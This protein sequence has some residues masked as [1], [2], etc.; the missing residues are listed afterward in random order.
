MIPRTYNNIY[1]K[2]H[3]SLTT[4]VSHVYNINSKPFLSSL[5]FWDAR[6]SLHLTPEMVVFY[7]LRQRLIENI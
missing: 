2:G 7:L 3:V 5:V 6:K 4:Q 1:N